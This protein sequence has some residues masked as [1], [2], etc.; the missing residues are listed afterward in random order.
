MIDKKK[1]LGQQKKAQRKRKAQAIKVVKSFEGCESSI[2]KK[3]RELLTAEG[4]YHIQEYS[5]RHTLKGKTKENYKVYDFCVRG[6]NKKDKQFMFLIECDGTYWHGHAYLEGTKPY[7]K[8]TKIQKR[9]LKNDKLKD[10]IAKEIGM[11]LL[12]LKECDIKFNINGVK[13]DIYKMVD[14]F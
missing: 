1:Y 8:L 7:S 11:P 6:T 3:V 2:E 12:R 4:I 9:N 13:D 5:V 14:M 10:K